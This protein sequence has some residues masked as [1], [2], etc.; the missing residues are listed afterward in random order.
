[1]ITLAGEGKAKR[2]TRT[3][4]KEEMKSQWGRKCMRGRVEKTARDREREIESERERERV[5]EV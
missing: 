5:F 4:G 2:G 1:M 3:K